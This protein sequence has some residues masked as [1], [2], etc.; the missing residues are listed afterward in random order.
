MFTLIAAAIL[1]PTAS[2]E[3]VAAFFPLNPGDSW[4]YS[5]DSDNFSL[6]TI[7]TVGDPVAQ[8]G[9]LTM[10]PVITTRDGKELDRVYYRLNE[11]EVV[12]VAFKE[13]EPL[14]A[15]YPILVS[16][17]ARGSWKY[18]GET[19]MQGA[20]TDMTMD[21]KVKKGT[22]EWNG[23]KIDSLEVRLEATLMESFGTPYDVTQVAVYGRGIGL[24]K[25]ESTTK[26]PKRSIKSTRKLV[27]YRPKKT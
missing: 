3:G 19:F 20:L 12:V 10:T 4:I 11:G 27:E 18:K 17:D 13:K 2:Y 8:E 6:R 14:L 16:P 7:D 5:E 25:M 15:A 9:G 22:V 26:L 23:K 1:A 21:G 24:I